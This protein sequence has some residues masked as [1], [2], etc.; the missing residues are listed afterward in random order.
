MIFL[1]DADRIHLDKT[2]ECDGR[3][4]GQNSS[5]CYS[6]L[7]CV[8]CGRAVKIVLLIVITKS[9]LRRLDWMAG[10]IGHQSCDLSSAYSK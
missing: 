9:A 7:H 6:G 5:G 10:L 2:P 3:T 8:Q 1:P 4:D